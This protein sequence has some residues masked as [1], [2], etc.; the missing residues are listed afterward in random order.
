METTTG[1]DGRVGDRALDEQHAV[2]GPAADG[3]RERDD[4]LGLAGADRHAGLFFGHPLGGG[5]LREDDEDGEGRVFF[6]PNRPGCRPIPRSTDRC[7]AGARHCSDDGTRASTNAAHDGR[8][9]PMNRNGR[10]PLAPRS[11]ESRFPGAGPPSA[12]DARPRAVSVRSPAQG[13]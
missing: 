8:S 2:D 4:G 7:G 10:A 9:R 11:R 5:R 6:P 12:G 3:G 13:F 1:F